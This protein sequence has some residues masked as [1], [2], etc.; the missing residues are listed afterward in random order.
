MK[1]EAKDKPEVIIVDRRERGIT[2]CQKG[3]ELTDDNVFLAY[4]G[5]KGRLYVQCLTCL[6]ARRDSY[7]EKCRRRYQCEETYREYCKRKTRAY[8]AWV[9]QDKKRAKENARPETV[10]PLA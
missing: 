3:H 7:N 4:G 5:Y 6:N 9:R 2:H 1:P 10:R 8:K